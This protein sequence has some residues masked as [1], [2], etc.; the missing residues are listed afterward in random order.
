MCRGWLQTLGYGPRLVSCG[1][2]ALD[3]RPLRENR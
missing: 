3:G 1:P 2:S